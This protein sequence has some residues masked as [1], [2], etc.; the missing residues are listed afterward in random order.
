[1]IPDGYTQIKDPVY[2]RVW[3]CPNGDKVTHTI[4]PHEG[5]TLAVEPIVGGR[6]DCTL[7]SLDDCIHMEGYL[8]QNVCGKWQLHQTYR[9]TDAK[10]SSQ[11]TTKYKEV[12][13]EGTSLLQA[14]EQVS[15]L[16]KSPSSYTKEQIQDRIEALNSVLAQKTAYANDYERNLFALIRQIVRLAMFSFK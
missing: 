3:V 7:V 12:F 10:P 9:I 2:A 14:C 8:V 15:F 5:H 1:M 6:V 16:I 13:G 11:S 4:Y